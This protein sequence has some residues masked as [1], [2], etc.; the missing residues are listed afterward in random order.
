M[1]QSVDSARAAQYLRMSTDMQQYSLDNQSVAIGA[2]AQRHGYVVVRSYEDGARSGLQMTGRA[3]LANLIKDVVSGSADFQT[4]LVYDVSRWGRFQDADESAYYEFILKQAGVRI[5]YCAEQFRNDGTLS[6]MIVKNIKRAMA[7]EYSREL[8]VKV[9]A[10]QSRLVLMGHYF[11]GAP[12]YGLRR[13]LVDQNNNRKFEMKPGERKSLH[14]EHTILVPGPQHEVDIIHRVYQLFLDEGNTVREIVNWLN[15]VGEPNVRGRRW[16]YHNVRELLSN[17]KYAGTSVFNRTSKKFKTNWRRN[18]PSE[19]VKGYNAFEPIVPMARLLAAQ[20]RLVY[21]PY[22][23]SDGELLAI[24]CVIWCKHGFLS[25]QLIASHPHAPSDNTYKVR[26]GSLA[27]AYRWIGF[28]TLRNLN[29]EHRRNLRTRITQSIVQEFAHRGCDVQIHPKCKS[30]FRVNGCLD[31]TVVLGRASR[32]GTLLGQN[33]WQFGYR[34]VRKPHILIVARTDNESSE[35]RDYFLLPFV[36]LPP[37]T[38]V[39]A[40]GRN[41]VRLDRF[42]LTSIKAL[43]DRCTPDRAA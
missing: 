3:A 17:E 27:N 16:S 40:S 35:V 32:S 6:S 7:G 26:F 13:M 2:Y 33:N 12:G 34:S 28:S 19:W 41:Y 10:G 23:H 37:G 42:R 15:A 1:L 31:I 20:K 25:R 5:E 18:P 4:L 38:W 36:F 39:T 24:L 9:H 29:R 21:D 8:S 11:G 22:K 30:E 43:A 14:T